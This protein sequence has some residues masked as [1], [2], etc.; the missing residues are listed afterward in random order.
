[1]LPYPGQ[2]TEA[3]KTSELICKAWKNVISGYTF[4]NIFPV[5]EIAPLDSQDISE[6]FLD[7]SN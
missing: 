5:V 4:I 7:I 6:H 1:M 2:T 3:I